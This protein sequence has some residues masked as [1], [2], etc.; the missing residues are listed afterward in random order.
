MTDRRAFTLIELLVVIAIIALLLAILMPSLRRARDQGKNVTCRNNLRQI[1]LAFNLYT[2]DN[3]GK[4]PRNGG[5]WIVRFLPYIGG[6]GDQ[7]R[8]YRE[9][10][11]YNC[12]MYPNKE[13]TLDYVINSW[14][15][16]V[17]EH[18]G[19]SPVSDFR[20]PAS[21]IF[22]ADNEDGPSRPVITEDNQLSGRG[23]F[24]VWRPSH[25]PSGT[26]QSRRVAKA[27]HRDGCNVAYMDGGSGWVQAE[28]MTER[29]WEPE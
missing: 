5:I 29:M 2:E 25:L 28:K 21:K 10:A 6:Q 22:L 9:M 12:P 7:D 11:V 18:I 27:R 1:G 23:N 15:D 26:D 19:F 8:D 4:F 14:K 20:R 17:T 16:G 24:D 13:Q 3:E